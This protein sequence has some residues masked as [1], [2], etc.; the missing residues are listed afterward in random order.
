MEGD[1]GA[2]SLIHSNHFTKHIKALCYVPLVDTV[3]SKSEAENFTKGKTG[4]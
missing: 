3:K 2:N 4:K 1:R